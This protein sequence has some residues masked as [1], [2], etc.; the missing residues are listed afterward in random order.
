MRV[1]FVLDG[2]YAW[3]SGIWFHR[4]HLPSI[5][6]KNRGHS[7][8]FMSLGGQISSE[9]L[10]FP[11]TVIFGRTYHPNLQP[12]AAVRQ[13]KAAGKRVL[14][15]IDDDFWAVNPEN[16]SV[17]VSNAY[18]DQYE[19]FIK[20]CDAVITPSQVLARKIRRL[21][22][23]K[24]VFICHNSVSE[25]YYLRRPHKNELTIG[26]AGGA[27]HWKDLS[28]VIDPLVAL[29]K[30]YN[31]N[32]TLLGMVGAPLEGEI[33]AYDQMLKRGLQPEKEE[34][35]RSAIDWYNKLKGLEIYHVPFYPPELYPHV[36]RRC[37]F[38]IALAP[39]AKNEFN[40][41]KSCIKFYEYAA[42]GSATIASDVQP[43]KSE[44]SYRAKNTFKDWYKKIERLIVD[45]EFR[46][47]LAQK[48]EKWVWE[49]RS[50]HK[51]ALG[52]EIAC[53]RPGGLKVK[54]QQQELK[55]YGK[56][57]SSN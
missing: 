37:D 12:E 11:D 33:Y 47:K 51:T 30:K 20:E 18:K 3:R 50:T 14:Y 31:F 15:D 26:Y 16:P 28:I 57:K 4:N 13:Y 41:A 1:L 22:P 25:N 24:E 17:L 48:Q 34:Y 45:K 52:W 40:R 53:Q 7:I 46:L 32:F 44:V 36:L 23:G 39:L 8:K 2:P 38:D 54:R 49:N 9:L 10:E 56:N 29:K 35:L 27:S 43:Y 5:G 42:V 55:S 6:L 21:S 19:M